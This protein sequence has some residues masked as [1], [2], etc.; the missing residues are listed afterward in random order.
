MPECEYTNANMAESCTEKLI[1]MPD[2]PTCILAPDDFAALGVIRAIRRRGLR[3]P[4]DI[5][6][7][8]YD[9][10]SISQTLVPKLTTVRQN[11]EKIGMEAARK[12]IRLIESPMTTTI[13]NCLVRGEFIEGESVAKLL[14]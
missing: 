8:G 14:L 6:V 2:R 11:S 1:D 12:L 5:S 3:V 13:E 4:E 9:G 7:A 10:I